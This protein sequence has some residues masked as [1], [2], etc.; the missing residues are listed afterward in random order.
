MQ[1]SR[2][3]DTFIAT[4]ISL[5]VIF[6]SL[7]KGDALYLGTWYYFTVPA[8][9]L[10]LCAIIKPAPLFLT[11]ASLGIAITILCVMSV[12]WNASRP[13]GLLGLGHIFSLP[14]AIIGVLLAA[15]KARGQFIQLP[16][17]SLSMGLGG[18][19]IGYLINQ[20]IICNT[21]MWCGPLS[22]TIK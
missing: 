14:G 8:I 6:I 5:I 10:S 7:T 1:P 16:Y 17:T 21:V 11:G 12:N 20:T 18:I 13:E 9:I 22:L 4:F 19:L 3:N 15:K 2:A